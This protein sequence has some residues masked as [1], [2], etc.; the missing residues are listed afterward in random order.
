[1][2]M[3]END[4]RV[5]RRMQPAA[6]KAAGL[7]TSATPKDK[8]ASQNGNQIDRNGRVKRKS[9]QGGGNNQFE[10]PTGF[11]KLILH[12]CDN[13]ELAHARPTLG[14]F[15]ISSRRQTTNDGDFDL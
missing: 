7:A 14:G 1:M 5:L 9:L 13:L 3:A 15:L 11:E 2:S 12:S 10:R 6:Y 4:S 8:A